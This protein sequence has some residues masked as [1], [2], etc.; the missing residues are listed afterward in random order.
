[1]NCLP[2]PKQLRVV[3]LLIEGNS[4]SS[5]ARITGV[6]RDTCTGV[7]IRF[8][9]ACRKFLSREMRDLELRHIQIDEIWTFCRKK[10]KRIVGDE[11]DLDQIGDIYIF[12][13]LDEDSRLVPAFRVGRRNAET[14]NLF[15]E[16]L[17]DRLKRPKP[18]A[19]DN[20]A[21]EVGTFK[22]TTRI[23][24]DA[25]PAYPEAIDFAFGPHAHYAQIDKKATKDGVSTNKN[26][27]CGTI[28]PKDVSTSLVERN[29]LTIRTFMRRLMRR[30]L[31]FSK[32]FANLE[33]ATALHLAYY[34]YCWRH[35]TFGTSPAVAA[36]IA[37]HRMS[38]HELFEEIKACA[39]EYF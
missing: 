25:F 26:V 15:M 5:T 28:E 8:G 18:H 27:I 16:D 2:V 17:A 34:N 19:S 11:P 7:M 24:T 37:D 23:S 12:V 29:N 31:G 38:L 39:P 36:G 9:N 22:P 13:A 4:L 35:K 20:H 6:H 3:K 30:T 32:K 14:T 33:A 21:F 10:Q 1:M